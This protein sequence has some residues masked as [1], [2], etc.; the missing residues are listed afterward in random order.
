MS[1]FDDEIQLLKL[2]I[3][4][5]EKQ[6]KEEEECFN[7]K[8]SIDYN[9]KII[10]DVL[11]NK[12]IAIKNNKYTKSSTISKIL[13]QELIRRLEAI[14]NI[15]QILDN[16]LSDVENNKISNVENNKISDVENK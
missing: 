3:S 1:R 16:R 15:L 2:R 5:L 4:E 12:K 8:E 13:D 10:S 11:N 14:Y 7:I 6:K 9:F